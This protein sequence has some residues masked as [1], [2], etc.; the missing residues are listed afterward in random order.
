MKKR[1]WI[2]GIVV[3]LVAGGYGVK[4]YV[5]SKIGD[6]VVQMTKDPAIQKMIDK[7]IADGNGTQQ[8]K[9][10]AKQAAQQVATTAQQTGSNSKGDGAANTTTETNGTATNTG[11]STGNGSSD[12]SGGLQF[13]SRDEA[14]KYAMSKFSASEIA[15]FMSVYQNRSQMSSSEKAAIKAEVLSRFSASELK[16]MQVAASK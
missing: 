9:E 2:L 16:A 7:A 14:V 6:E 11:S 1:I 13:Q 15:H 4:Q 10:L 3:V 8:V 12:P 5:T